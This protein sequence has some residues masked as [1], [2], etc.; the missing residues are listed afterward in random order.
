MK[1]LVGFF[2]LCEG[3]GGGEGSKDWWRGALGPLRWMSKE[4]K[5][6]TL[7]HATKET[8]VK[9]MRNLCVNG[10]ASIAS[11]YARESK[12]W[13]PLLRHQQ[14]LY[15]CTHLEGFF[16][17][18][19][20]WNHLSEPSLLVW[21][22]GEIRGKYSLK[23]WALFKTLNLRETLMTLR[24]HK[25]ISVVKRKS[26][27]VACKLVFNWC[28]HD[29]FVTCYP[30]SAFSYVELLIWILKSAVFFCCQGIQLK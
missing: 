6:T 5:I 22:S 3:G 12:H 17:L 18:S 26:L 8:I 11:K 24:L 25:I 19:D 7:S 9:L 10:I 16:P 28:C 15:Y 21:E 1:M 30:S 27:A 29:Q 2:C 4:N 23:L 13:S 20:I 14:S